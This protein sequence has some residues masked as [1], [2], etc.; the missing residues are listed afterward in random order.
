VGLHE[1]F[2]C[3]EDDESA[4]VI[5]NLLREKIVKNFGER[6]FVLAPG[7]YRT[8]EEK[9]KKAGVKVVSNS[10]EWRAQGW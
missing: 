5:K 1:C 3:V 2:V 4:T 10:I 8:L 7:N 9:L 6:C